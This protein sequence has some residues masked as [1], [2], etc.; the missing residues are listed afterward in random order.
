VRAWANHAAFIYRNLLA[1]TQGGVTFGFT[2]Q[3]G[4]AWLAQFL[5]RIWGCA[6]VSVSASA[7]P[8][9]S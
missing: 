6:V 4:S 8:C 2:A 5:I 7:S 9:V 3:F 1:D